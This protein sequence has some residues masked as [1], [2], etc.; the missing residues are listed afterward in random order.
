MF[1]YGLRHRWFPQTAIG[2]LKDWVEEN[3]ENRDESYCLIESTTT[4]TYGKGFLVSSG[5]S[6]GFSA[7]SILYKT[8]GYPKNMLYC[9][10]ESENTAWFVIA[11]D[12]IL[13]GDHYIQINNNDIAKQQ[14]AAAKLILDIERFTPQTMSDDDVLT[15]ICNDTR[16]EDDGRT[17]VLL[18]MFKFDTHYSTKILTTD[19][20]INSFALANELTKE[21][22][23]QLSSSIKYP[24]DV[25]FVKAGFGALAILVLVAVACFLPVTSKPPAVIKEKPP[26]VVDTFKSL[27]KLLTS[28]EEAIGIKQRFGYIVEELNAARKIDGYNITHYSAN[29]EASSITL[30]RTFGNIDSVK[31]RLPE[32]AFYYQPISGGLKLVRITPTFP[33][34]NTAV[35]ANTYAEEAWI[36][37]AVRFAW[38]EHIGEI[39]AKAPV[40]D[41]KTDK[42]ISYEYTIPFKGLYLEDLDSLS[43]LFVGRS[44][45]FEELEFTVSPDD[46]AYS[47]QLKIQI[48]G[49]PDEHFGIKKR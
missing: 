9:S 10:L 19:F 11:K 5:Q 2:Q 25:R 23:L 28:G 37:S 33:V 46:K 41:R 20:D 48:I 39:K 16:Q 38:A 30:N 4:T 29:K 21:F 8:L 18:G 49:V 45:S 15:I 27:K 3:R 42:F 26:V 7:A 17:T 43:S 44:A 1:N 36:E 24:V 40:K 12:G 13:Y 47:G 32:S 35:R 34:F 22:G 31:A 6:D 14:H